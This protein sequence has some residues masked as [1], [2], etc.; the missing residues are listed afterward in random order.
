MQ[1]YQQW[2]E[3][4]G[5]AF[6]ENT[7]MQCIEFDWA[8]RNACIMF[9]DGMI[10]KETLEDNIL[11]RLKQDKNTAPVT[12]ERLR[13]LTVYTTPIQELTDSKQAVL[14]LA[15]GDI[16]L[17]A[18]GA[19][20]IF[21]YSEKS[22]NVRSISEPPVASVLRGPREGFVEDIKVNMT[23]LRRRLATPKLRTKM[24]N[25]GKYSHT[26]ICLTYIEGIADNKIVEG[27][28][29][30]I[31]QIDID[32]IVE[33]SYI[34]RY[35]E[36]NPTSIF[37]Q[38]GNTEKPDILTAKLLEGRV[39]IIVDGSPAVLTV[40]F[41]LFES[42]QA[43]EDY[44]VK[45]YRASLVRGAR[46]FAMLC[47]VLLPSIYV[48]LQQFQYQYLPYKF[49]LSI[50]QSSYS[51]PFTPPLEMLFV[52]LVFE[53]LSEASIRMPKHVGTALSV[54]GAIVLG[55]SAVEAGILSSQTVFVMAISTIGMY[56]VPD[57]TN[58]ASVLRIVGVAISGVLGMLGI[59]L[60]GIALTVYLAHLGSWGSSFLSPYAPMLW[61]DLQDGVLKEELP[62]I[63]ERPFS[64]PTTNRTRQRKP[65][66]SRNRSTKM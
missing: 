33:S 47:A 61:H 4:I 11:L 51:L 62:D 60:G 34:A 20:K 54:V 36:S 56:C 45:S 29:Q 43:S 27:V 13:A 38:V 1:N 37:S 3:Y 57:Q 2:V 35:L 5:Q 24:L 22:Y 19:E 6:G 64:I 44:Y 15:G 65:P 46:L 14:Q 59:V 52:L 10:D 31:A 30:R 25:V 12:I 50:A 39:G 66:K 21:V 16:L 7:D 48:A 32:G 26:K 55:Q 42:F 53:V 41:L 17:L 40:P 58:T 8:G 63:T 9:L 49:L 28:G 18:D 23:M